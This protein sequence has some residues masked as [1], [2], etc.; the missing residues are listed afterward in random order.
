MLWPHISHPISLH[1]A[2]IEP[3]APLNNREI[4]RL[5]PSGCSYMGPQHIVTAAELS[6]EKDR[7]LKMGRVRDIFGDQ[8]VTSAEYSDADERYNKILQKPL[9][10][11]HISLGRTPTAVEIKHEADQLGIAIEAVRELFGV[12]A[13]L[14]DVEYGESFVALLRTLF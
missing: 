7:L 3:P 12:E 9:G 1:L 4:E 11:G 13:A 5:L 14:T 2:G 6:R 10:C 8:A